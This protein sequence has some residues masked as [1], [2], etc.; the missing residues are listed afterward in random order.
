MQ[1]G[2]FIGIDLS[3]AQLD[4]CVWPDDERR[5]FDND[6]QGLSEFISFARTRSPDL[7]AF[8]HTGRLS[9]D[10]IVDLT[11][12]NIPCV[13]L[14]PRKVRALAT[15]IGRQAKTDTLDAHL[16]ARFAALIRPASSSSTTADEYELRDLVTRRQQLVAERRSEVVRRTQL[17]GLLCLTSV[18]RHIEWLKAETLL[19]DA[20]I[21]RRVSENEEWRRRRELIVSMPGFGRTAAHT[22]I[23]HLPE[24][25]H[26]E[27]K[28]ITALIGLA[29]LNWE[30][31][32]IVRYRKTG[33][34]RSTVRATLF[35]C[36]VVAARHNPVIRAFHTR[37]IEAG[38][39]KMVARVAVMRKMLTIVNAMIQHDEPWTTDGV[40]SD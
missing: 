18:N 25:G 2:C 36:S 14:D 3:K 34:G 10:L 5:S 31:G 30:S 4:A 39:P 29:P 19:I 17:Q 33:Y 27:G 21:D 13:L 35:M 11:N 8:E 7:V 6:S 23:A 32:T 15:V 40:A 26:H 22:L 9:R 24:L 37:L 28:R 16:I 12:H 20:D 1:M 38:K